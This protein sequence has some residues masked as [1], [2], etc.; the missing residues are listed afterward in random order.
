MD[1]KASDLASP[2]TAAPVFPKIDPVQ[3]AKA[4]GQPQPMT[5]PVQGPALPKA[6]ELPPVPPL[7]AKTPDNSKRADSLA[8]LPTTALGGTGDTDVLVLK[9]IETLLTE[10]LNL[11]REGGGTRLG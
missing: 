8:A 7:T 6:P 3:V 4:A 5:R 2:A 1:A 11:M 9:R 10:M